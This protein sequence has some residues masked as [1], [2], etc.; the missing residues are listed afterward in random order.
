[1]H[2][3]NTFSLK[4]YRKTFI[5]E[6]LYFIQFNLINIIKKKKLLQLSTFYCTLKID[7]HSNNYY[8]YIIKK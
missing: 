6:L 1:M 8:Y 4:Y 3:D 5:S 2:L 7:N